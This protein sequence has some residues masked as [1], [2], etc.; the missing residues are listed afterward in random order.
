M[1]MSIEKFLLYVAV[2]AGVTY[3]IRML[4]LVIFK[5]KIQSRFIKSFLF[6]VPYAVLAAMTIPDIFFSTGNV[7]SAVAGLVVA[8]ILAYFEKGLLTVALCA[9]GGILVVESIL[10]LL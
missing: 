3:L 2:M 10:K 5:K 7:W 4:P 9:C 6:Y 1:N 8:V